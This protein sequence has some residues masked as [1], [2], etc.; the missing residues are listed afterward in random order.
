MP[1]KQE[2]WMRK[3]DKDFEETLALF[4]SLDNREKVDGDIKA[5]KWSFHD[6]A[7]VASEYGEFRLLSRT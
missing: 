5:L 3:R 4:A 2:Q 7:S 6:L 1:S